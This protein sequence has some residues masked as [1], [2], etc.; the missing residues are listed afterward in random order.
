VPELPDTWD[1]VLALSRDRRVA[2]SVAGPH[3]FLSFCS[4][5]VAFGEQPNDGGAGDFVPAEPATRVF[6]LM[7]E[8]VGRAPAG[9]ETLNPIAMLEA[10]AAGDGIDYCPL[11]Y[12]YVN[13]SAAEAGRPLTF[14]EAPAAAPGGRRG[15]TIGGTGIAVTTRCT[16]SPELTEHLRWLLSPVAQRGFIPRHA[17]QP[18][19]RSAWTD[20]AVN[21]ASRNFYAD[22]LATIDASW[23]RP[24]YSGYIRFQSEASVLLRRAFAERSPAAPALGELNRLY[25][26]S[27]RSSN[28]HA[29]PVPVPT[30][31]S[32]E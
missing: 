21:R 5:L 9:A 3:A 14:G 17:G 29:V 26:A 1:D 15:S 32:A 6:E 31:G 28:S 13:Y 27:V 18:S 22:T 25:E 11:V 20:D 2:L 23:V 16:P 30:R 24:R 12:G 8:L 10:M 7:A 19:A 4:I